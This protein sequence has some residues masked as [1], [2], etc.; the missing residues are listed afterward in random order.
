MIDALAQHQEVLERLR[1][2]RTAAVLIAFAELGVADALA[3][4]PLPACDIAQRIGADPAATARFL[5]A[6]TTLSLVERVDDDVFANAPLAAHG[7]VSNGPAPLVNL[8]RREAAFYKR[9]SN[10]AEAVRLG[11]RPAANIRDEDA[12][13]WVRNFT[14][15][16]YDTA[17]LSAPAIAETL[18]PLIEGAAGSVRVLDVGGGS[19]GYSL[20]VAARYPQVEALVFDLPPVIATT[21]EIIAGSGLDGRVRTLAGDFRVAADLDAA[22]SGY[23]LALVFGVL[24]GGDADAGRA[25]LRAVHAAL[26]PGG[27]VV[28]RATCGQS[29]LGPEEATLQDLHMLLSTGAGGA[30]GGSDVETW[31]SAVGFEHVPPLPLPADLHGQLLL[32][33]R[34]A[35]KDGAG[36]PSVS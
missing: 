23:H 10:L 16:G 5:R 4:G 35:E 32:G 17:R 24:V 2:F 11:Q 13:D 30:H 3:D 29:M 27:H 15:A 21:R 22:G 9:W 1:G 28:I 31:L 12:P 19:G 7:L 34:G 14:L 36:H 25:L 33:R 26:V 18:A 8:V 6:A 20:A